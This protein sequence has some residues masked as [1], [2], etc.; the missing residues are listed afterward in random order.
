MNKILCVI[1][2]VLTVI[3][4]S[5]SGAMA[6]SYQYT[7]NTFT[8][9]DG[10][11]CTTDDFVSATL[12]FDNWLPANYNGDVTGFSGFSLV[13]NAGTEVFDSELA[14]D[15]GGAVLD[16]EISTNGS[17][18]IAAWNLGM[19]QFTFDYWYVFSKN[20]PGVSVKDYTGSFTFGSGSVSNNPGTWTGPV[21]PEPISSILFV[22]GG[23]LLAG[24][25]Y[26]RRKKKALLF[27][28][29]I[30]KSQKAC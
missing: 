10:L 11:C 8:V 23:T 9:V 20:Q 7:G 13:M 1:M 17:G 15:Y 25:K 3:F 24:R 29:M 4:A 19:D 5:V 18:E 28:S 2:M 14:G 21:V 26:I 6:V 22:T 27:I 16:A 30:L 12:S